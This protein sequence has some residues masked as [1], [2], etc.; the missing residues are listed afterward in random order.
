MTD[1]PLNS[2]DPSYKVRKSDEALIHQW[3]LV[4]MS[5]EMRRDFLNVDYVKELWDDIPKYS[6]K[7]NHDWWIYE[8]NARASQAPQGSDS[9]M[10]YASNLKAI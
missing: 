5:L 1:P 4:S 6:E 9:V 2:T 7:R 10:T 8:L 3:I